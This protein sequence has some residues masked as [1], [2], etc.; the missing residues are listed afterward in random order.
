MD[1]GGFF[2]SE[3]KTGNQVGNFEQAAQAFGPAGS[4]GEATV[5]L[6]QYLVQ[7]APKEVYD[8]AQLLRVI[9][10]P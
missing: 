8:H 2:I 3:I 6:D 5:E 9:S 10:K 7:Y 1:R 4:K